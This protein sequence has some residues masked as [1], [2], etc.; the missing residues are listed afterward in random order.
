MPLKNRITQVASDTARYH[1]SIAAW[2]LVV[3]G[4]IYIVLRSIFTTSDFIPNGFM[5]FIY[6]PAKIFSL[7]YAISASNSFLT[8]FVRHGVTRRDYFFGTSIALVFVSFTMM[9]ITAGIASIENFIFP[10]GETASYFESTGSVLATIG[11][12]SL[13]IICYYIT[14]WL[15]AILFYGFNTIGKSLAIMGASLIITMSGMLWGESGFEQN[16]TRLFNLHSPWGLPM[17]ISF[18]GTLLLIALVL[19][20]IRASS[21][22]ITV[23]MK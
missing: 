5:D 17:A 7:I 13:N 2:F 8:F 20:I 11:E 18:L 22:N 10:A 6:R 19:W 14:G 9:I 21:K 3:I 12:Y 15:I 1:L 23:K 4:I 16:I